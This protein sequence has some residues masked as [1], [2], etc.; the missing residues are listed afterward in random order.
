METN[1][2]QMNALTTLLS[3]NGLKETRDIASHTDTI[4]EFIQIMEFDIEERR[5]AIELATM[6]I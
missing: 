2:K 4:E 5:K 6:L 1:E 3:N